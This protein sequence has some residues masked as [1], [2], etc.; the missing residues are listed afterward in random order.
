MSDIIESGQSEDVAPFNMTQVPPE[1]SVRFAAHEEIEDDHQEGRKR[2]TPCVFPN[3]IGAVENHMEQMAM[4]IQ[5]LYD[6]LQNATTEQAVDQLLSA[7]AQALKRRLSF[8]RKWAELK[9]DMED[10]TR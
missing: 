9:A 3:D 7:L 6:H 5:L 10:W 8:Q 2:S 4:H 1:R